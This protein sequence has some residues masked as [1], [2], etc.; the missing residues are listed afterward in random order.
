MMK[1]PYTSMAPQTQSHQ[2][3]GLHCM[4][5]KAA[6]SKKDMSTA[7]R[8]SDFMKSPSHSHGVIVLKPYLFSILK[9]SYRLKGMFNISLPEESATKNSHPETTKEKLRDTMH[10]LKTFNSPP[11]IKMTVIKIPKRDETKPK[12]VLSIS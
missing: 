1:S 5:R 12:Y 3:A 11:K 9:C 7:E 6:I 2:C 4:S 8:S 10:E